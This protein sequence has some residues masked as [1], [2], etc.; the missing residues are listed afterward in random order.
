MTRPMPRLLLTL[1]V[2][3]APALAAAQMPPM[4]TPGPEHALLKE[5]AGTWDAVI[6]MTGPDG[7][8]M[9]SKGVEVNTMGCNGLCL[10]TD[11]KGEL[12]PGM[13]FAGS[14]VTAFDPK[15]K[16]YVGSWSDSMTPGLATSEGTWDP[17]A[18]KLT[19]TMKGTG[20]DGQPST[21]TAVVEY[22]AAGKRVMTLSAPGPDGK[23]AQMLK[24][25]YTKRS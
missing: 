12:M 6:E 1:C 8:T 7:S 11:F 18:K 24:I 20:A 2:W 25:T 15:T 23:P 14:G 21:T 5:D 10:V 16:K 4:P 13:S 22:P 17:A 9:S 19:S 3:L